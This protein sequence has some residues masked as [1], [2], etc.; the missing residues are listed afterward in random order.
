MKTKM[1]KQP[2][3]KQFGEW[4]AGELILGRAML[5]LDQQRGLD[6]TDVCRDARTDPWSILWRLRNQIRRE[7]RAAIR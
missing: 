4:F 1:P 6:G 5:H 2:T 7:R 3:R